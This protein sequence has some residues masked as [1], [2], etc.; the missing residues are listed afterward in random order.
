MHGPYAGGMDVVV[1]ADTHLRAGVD[2]L[3]AALLEALARADLVLHA[4]DVTSP[5]ALA[6]LRSLSP[7]HAVLGNNDTDLVGVLPEDLVLDLDGVRVALVHDSGPRAGR[8]GRLARRYPDAAVVVFGH[9][10]IPAD[11]EGLSGQRLFNPGSATQRRTQPHASFGR[12]VLARGSVT[13]HAIEP[14]PSPASVR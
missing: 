13:S 2:G 3:P 12:L 14:L 8:P 9:S 10:H 1:L 4:G 5:R 11:E 7:L 6:E